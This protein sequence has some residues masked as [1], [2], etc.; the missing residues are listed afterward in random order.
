MNPADIV[1]TDVLECA[2]DPAKLM[3]F[4]AEVD[5][6]VYYSHLFPA[7][8]CTL[9][10]LVILR[11]RGKGLPSLM[12]IIIALLFA[13]FAIFDL[14]LWAIADPSQIMF[15]WSLLTYIEP[16]IYIATLY[17]VVS[18]AYKR[19]LSLW[20][21][22]ALGALFAPII[23]FGPTSLN[24]AAY[25]YTNC[26][27]LAVE[28]S[29]L[30]Y[31]YFIEIVIVG[32]ILVTTII[33]YRQATEAAF[34]RSIIFLTAGSLFFLLA[35]SSGNIMGTFMQGVL[36]ED[37]WFYGQYGLFGMPLFLGFI[38]YLIVQ[39]K[40]FNIKLIGAEA[41]TASLWVL[42][43]ALLFVNNITTARGVIIITLILFTGLGFLLIRSVRR[44]VEHREEIELLA[45]KLKKANKRLK[46]LDQMKS[47]FVSIASHQLR[48]PL[49]SIRGYASMLLEGSYGK[50]SPKATE[51]I[52]RISDSSTYMASSIEDYL[53]V[54]RIEAGNMK[55]EL[56]DFNLKGEAEH[57]ADDKRQEA[58][59]KGLL[60]SFKSD[61]TRQ[62][63][64]NADIGKTRQILHNLVNNALKYTPRGTVTV[65][66]HDDKKK[67]KIYVDIIDSGIGMKSDELEDIFRKFERAHNANQTNVTGTGLGL[68][69]ARKMAR[70]MK[71][72]VTAH[73]EGVGHG[74]TFRLEMPLQM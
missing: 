64:V 3:M 49:T 40:A 55:Y 11:G 47:E 34:K 18:F 29:L 35:F 74:S 71:G 2:W 61:V 1:R 52:E 39:F 38:L 65:F 28:G 72:D 69:V 62:G 4:S 7:I 54:S 43:L 27:R 58:L 17:L 22:L 51:A 12:F 42:L 10:A 37:A 6:L 56:S 73:S 33:A 59:K 9:L 13:V 70:E 8:A 30:L 50:L 24:L 25:D 66:A 57:V 41:L 21:K 20:A 31:V 26:D 16:L 48:S 32:W 68:F 19:D 63:I 46:V 44:E 45:N 5:P 23:L 67:K 36:G 53:N 14:F 15:F 60:I